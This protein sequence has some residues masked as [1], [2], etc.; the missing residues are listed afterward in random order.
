[1][2]DGRA[3]ITAAMTLLEAVQLRRDCEAV[4]RACDARAGC[5]LLCHHLFD[6][7]G[8]VAALYSLDLAQLLREC[9]V[10][11]E[12]PVSGARPSP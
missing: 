5:C 7:I 4:F 8:H 6:S 10:P 12:A 1:M 11:V 9:N 3:P 2:S